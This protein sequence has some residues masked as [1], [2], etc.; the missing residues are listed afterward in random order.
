MQI[1]VDS[2]QRRNGQTPPPQFWGAT[3]YPRYNEFSV[4]TDFILT[5]FH[6][7]VK[8]DSYLCA[9]QNSSYPINSSV[10]Y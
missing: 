5:G 8:K 7:S 4:L 3:G 9:K 2:D 1:S 6:C 10:V